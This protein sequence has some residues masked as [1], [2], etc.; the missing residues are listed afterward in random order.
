MGGFLVAFSN[1]FLLQSSAS[2]FPIEKW[3]PFQQDKV[4]LHLLTFAKPFAMIGLWMC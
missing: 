1:H 3:A 2:V 4:K